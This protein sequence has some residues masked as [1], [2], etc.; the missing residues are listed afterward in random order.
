MKIVDDRFITAMT[1]VVIIGFTLIM[2]MATWEEF[3]LKTVATWVLPFAFLVNFG[4][5][6]EFGIRR[7]GFNYV[8]RNERMK[9]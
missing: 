4:I 8:L 6:V 9:F 1:F 2:G 3:R 7:N 5:L